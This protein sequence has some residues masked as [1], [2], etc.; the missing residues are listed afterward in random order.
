M[1]F[2]L[3]KGK[4]GLRQKRMETHVTTLT[5]WAYQFV[6]PIVLTQFAHKFAC[7]QSL[8]PLARHLL[9]SIRP[10]YENAV[11]TGGRW[12]IFNQEPANRP[13]VGN[14]QVATVLGG[15]R[16]VKQAIRR[17]R[18]MFRYKTRPISSG[19]IK[20]ACLVP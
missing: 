18:L 2:N 19:F 17:N 10:Q 12:S 1:I 16:F 8:C 9:G 15:Q 20:G 5:R 6:E 7:Y 13:S 3:K 4:P 14:A 11:G